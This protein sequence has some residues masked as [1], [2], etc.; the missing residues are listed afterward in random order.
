M[1]TLADYIAGD[2]VDGLIR[3]LVGL[4]QT[5]NSETVEV[6]RRLIRPHCRLAI[7]ISLAFGP[8]VRFVEQTLDPEHRRAEAAWLRRNRTKACLPRRLYQVFDLNDVRARDVVV[9]HP[10]GIELPLVCE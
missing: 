2:E 9:Q 6:D 4:I 10:H 1:I 3:L 5:R 8:I 7:F